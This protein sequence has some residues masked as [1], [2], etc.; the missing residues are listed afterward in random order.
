[1]GG[2]RVAVNGNGSVNGQRMGR[3]GVLGAEQS[4]EIQPLS[5]LTSPLLTEAGYVRNDEEDEARRKVGIQRVRRW[6]GKFLVITELAP[7]RTSKEF[8]LD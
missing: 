5:P 7:R 1:M 8:S 3:T 2:P 6:M 4:A